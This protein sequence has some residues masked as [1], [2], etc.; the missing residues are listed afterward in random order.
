MVER[1]RSTTTGPGGSDLTPEPVTGTR[2]RD[3]AVMSRREMVVMGLVVVVIAV[4]LGWWRSAHGADTAT[5]LQAGFSVI[6]VVGSGLTV[7][8]VAAR[9]RARRRAGR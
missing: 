3:K 8:Q 4:A 2:T 5:A 1:P 6:V 7:N 9:R